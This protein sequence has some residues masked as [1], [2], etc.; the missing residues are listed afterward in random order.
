MTKCGIFEDNVSAIN[1]RDM[2]LQNSTPLKLE[3]IRRY[4]VQ[5][6]EGVNLHSLLF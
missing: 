3:K 2:Q 5:K 6:Y 4:H 1:F